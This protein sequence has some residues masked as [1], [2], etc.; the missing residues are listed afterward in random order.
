V[1]ASYFGTPLQ[2]FESI[3]ALSLRWID[4][5]RGNAASDDAGNVEHQV[6][7]QLPR[8]EMAKT[9]VLA[10]D[11]QEIGSLIAIKLRKTGYEVFWEH[12]GDTALISV[13]KNLPQL[14]IA[15]LN[16][17]GLSGFDLVASVREGSATRDTPIIILTAST[18]K[19]DVLKGKALGV[20]EYVLKPF[21]IDDLMERVMR[22]TGSSQ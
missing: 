7:E 4:R 20:V 11:S 8:T 12:R 1:S 14:V 22:L 17:P 19:E 13:K 3:H 21:R 18:A 15:D 2:R 9:I 16:L 10:E 6:N 5:Q